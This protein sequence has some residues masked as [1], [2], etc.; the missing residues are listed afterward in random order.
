MTAGLFDYPR[1]AAF[2][3]VLPKNKIYEH[4]GA[5]AGGRAIETL[6][7]ADLSLKVAAEMLARLAL[8]TR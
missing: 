6:Q 4:A 1:S 3:R 7:A 2:G 5:S 8:G